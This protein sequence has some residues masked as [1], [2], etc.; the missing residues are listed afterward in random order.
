MGNLGEE[1]QDDSAGVG[2][3]AEPREADTG[4]DGE[5]TLESAVRKVMEQFTEEGEIVNGSKYPKED[6]IRPGQAF[7]EPAAGAGSFERTP[8]GQGY[9]K[10]S[11]WKG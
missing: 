6:D 8:I 5:I 2:D 9:A 10:G 3:E 11:G 1:S 4:D 7:G